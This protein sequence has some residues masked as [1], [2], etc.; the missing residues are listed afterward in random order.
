MGEFSVP[1]FWSLQYAAACHTGFYTCG[2]KRF[3]DSKQSCDT[4]KQMLCKETLLG[5]APQKNFVKNSYLEI[6][7]KSDGFWQLA[8]YLTLVFTCNY[9]GTKIVRFYGIMYILINIVAKI[10]GGGGGGG[11]GTGL[12]GGF[13][14]FPPPPP[15]PPLY[16]TL[17]SSLRMHYI[18]SYPGLHP[19]FISQP[20]RKVTTAR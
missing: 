7:C 12:W 13:P 6:T 17:C 5:H 11:G 20:W 15:P 1:T 18:T 3:G 4:V 9:T 2:G 16:E 19:D 10:L 14:R 8:D